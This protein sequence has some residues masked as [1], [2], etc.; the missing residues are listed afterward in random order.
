V[1]DQR[2]VATA[3]VPRTP[4]SPRPRRRRSPG[5]RDLFP[6]APPAR[7]VPRRVVPRRVG[8]AVAAVAAGA[9]VSLARQPGAGA[10]DTVWAED[11]QVFLADAVTRS[12]PEA[13]ATSYAGYFHTGP[14]LLAAIAAAAPPQWAAA[15]LATGAALATA[16]LALLVHTASAAHL[17]WQPA[18][19][20]AAAV[21]VV[22]PLAQQDVPNSIA[23]LHWPA[24]YALFW[25]LLWTPATRPGRIVAAV[26][27][28]LVVTSD[29]LVV[30]LLPLAA[31]RL[32]RRRDRHSA[33]LAAGFATGVGLQLAGLL[34]G[35]STR[36][37]SLDPARAG[38]GYLLRAVPGALVGSRW[39]GPGPSSARWFLLAALAWLLVAAVVLVAVRRLTSPAWG[40]AAVAGV[41]SAALY[42]LP[43]FLS[44]VATERY[45]VAPAMLLVVG[46]LALVSPGRAGPRGRGTAGPGLALVALLAVVCAANLRVDNARAG[47]PSWQ[48]E[49]TAARTACTA[50]EGTTRARLRLS[51][52]EPPW[53]ATLPCHYL[54]PLSCGI[55][56]TI[57]TF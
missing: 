3:A 39:L 14:R 52:M 54:A 55:S 49:L 34:T 21:V 12:L 2:R 25:V 4:E 5:G 30:A 44:G 33:V 50:G 24:L 1:T 41:H 10:L 11:G 19:L 53:F 35:A 27:T 20:A 28:A 36:E 18:R 45:A 15:A 26:A 6:D 13:L 47:G 37:T 48:A 22:V 46:L 32:W 43:V 8:L 56:R 7:V 57:Y 42:A 31:V 9:G 17:R 38:V 16:A 40:L 23:N 51:P 29:I